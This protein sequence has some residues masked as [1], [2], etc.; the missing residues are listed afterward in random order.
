MA[1]IKTEAIVLKRYDLRETSLLV[2][3]YTLDQGKIT[4]EMKGIREDPQKFASAV[5]LF[6]CNDIIF[7]EKRNSSVHL[8]S[9]CDLK[10]NFQPIRQNVYKITAA[11]AIIELIDG[12]MAQEDKNCEIF[13]L[14]KD[15]LSELSACESADKIVTIFKIKLLSLSGFKPH[16]DCCV[17]C[18]GNASSGQTRFSLHLGGLLCQRCSQKDSNAR[19]IFR[20]TIATIMHIEKNT[21]RENLKLGMNPQ[22]KRELELVLNSFLNYHLGKELKSDRT[23]QKL[24]DSEME[25][26]S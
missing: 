12:I 21:F 3:F 18:Q 14:T 17:S 4:G 13:A 2:N 5:E 22:I 26:G 16:L 20:G 8:V 15:A 24:Q 10:E 7:Y 19:T 25:S 6:S 9:Q 11:S 1:I 23:R